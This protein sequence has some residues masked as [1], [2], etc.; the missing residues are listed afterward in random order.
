MGSAV[1]QDHATA[2]QL[3]ARDHRRRA[4][5]AL[6]MERGLRRDFPHVVAGDRGDGRDPAGHGAHHGRGACVVALPR[7]PLRQQHR[8]RR[9]GCL[10]NGLLAVACLWTHPHGGG[11]CRA[12]STLRH[13]RPRAF[14]TP[15]RDRALA[16]HCTR[17]RAFQRRAGQ[18]GLHR[19]AR[20]RLRSAGGARAE[21]GGG[22]HGLHLCPAARGL[23]DRYRTGRGGLSVSRSRRAAPTERSP[24]E[25]VVDELSH[26]HGLSVCGRIRQSAGAARVRR[27]HDGGP[28]RRGLVGGTGF[29]TRHR[30]DGR[31]VQSSECLGECFWRLFRACARRQYCG[32]CGRAAAIR[33]AGISR[34]RRQVR[35]AR[36]RRWL[37]HLDLAGGLVDAARVVARRAGRGP[38]LRR[39]A[40][41]FH[42][43]PGG[44]PC[45]QLSRGRD[46][47]GQRGRGQR[48]R[49]APAHRQPPT[50]GQQCESA[51]RCT[52]GAVAHTAASGAQARAVSG[53]RHGGDGGCGCRRSGSAG[54][55]RRTAAGSDRG[56]ASFHRRLRPWRA[57]SALATHHRRRATLCA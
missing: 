38:R 51:R 27:E 41:G 46:G 14:P 15:R 43:G 35:A 23:S 30:R 36:C 34:P 9:A 22:E 56:V 2:Q 28:G 20:H 25:R 50:G 32:R 21:R 3:A 18:A 53:T 7:A 12:Q 1:D 42:R 39:A 24:A 48:R 13:H 6:A 54:R 55:C 8:G 31:L 44:R 45:G 52:A 17:C 26:R 33:R 5:A 11:V 16:F 57:Q 10:G 49:G 40:A 4:D 47:G 29:R 37:S 19:S